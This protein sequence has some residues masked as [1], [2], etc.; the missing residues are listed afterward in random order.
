[1]TGPLT[2]S[3]TSIEEWLAAYAA[4][5]RTIETAGFAGSRVDLAPLGQVHATP[6]LLPAESHSTH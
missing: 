3:S 2:R 4:G 1:M 6:F 5:V